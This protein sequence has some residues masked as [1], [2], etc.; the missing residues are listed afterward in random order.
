MPT[1]DFLF[2]K[3]K[4]LPFYGDKLWE[5]LNFFGIELFLHCGFILVLGNCEWKWRTIRN[6]AHLMNRG[7]LGAGELYITFHN[8]NTH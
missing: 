4:M 7:V 6:I 8:Y 3:L 2:R 5:R 1:F